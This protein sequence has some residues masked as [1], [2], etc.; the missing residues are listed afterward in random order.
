MHSITQK[1]CLVNF[2]SNLA[3]LQPWIWFVFYTMESLSKFSGKYHQVLPERLGIIYQTF[4]EKILILS[5]WAKN[6]HFPAII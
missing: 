1:S 6:C 2:E 3:I 5:I 4:D